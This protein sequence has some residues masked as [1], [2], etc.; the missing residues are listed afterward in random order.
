ML[1]SGVSFAAVICGCLLD[2]RSNQY[3]YIHQS[4]LW[5][6]AVEVSSSTFRGGGKYFAQE[7]KYSL[8]SICCRYSL[9]FALLFC[10]LW[11]LSGFEKATSRRQ[12][13]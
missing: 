13:A 5:F 7:S 6:C 9:P 11:V 8:G 10:C 2:I 1:R 4:K 12:S 3:L